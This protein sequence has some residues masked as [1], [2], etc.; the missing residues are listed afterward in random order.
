MGSE[1]RA[2]AVMPVQGGHVAGPVCT[3]RPSQEHGDE[4]E[5]GAVRRSH[6]EA[7]EDE[8]PCRHAHPNPS[9]V[10][11]SEELEHSEEDQRDARGPYQPLQWH[12]LLEQHDDQGDGTDR[13]RVAE[14]DG[15][16]RP[17]DGPAAFVLHAQRDREQP[18]HPG[19]DSVERAEREQPR[20]GL[21]IAHGKQYESEL[22]S[23][24]SRWTWCGR[25]PMPLVSTKKRSSSLIVPSAWT[26][27]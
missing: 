17:E 20:P 8:I 15:N 26:S 11:G 4:H 18:T 6:Q 23:P 13:E 10:P 25:S 3:Q 12:R 22:E 5:P 2:R 24:P 16:H 21:K 14:S 7:P 9:R 1:I 27:A 19:V